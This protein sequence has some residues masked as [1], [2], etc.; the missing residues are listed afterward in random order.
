[1]IIEFL[2][3]SFP[4]S[5][6]VLRPQSATQLA[7]ARLA[8]DHCTSRLSGPLNLVCMR[9]MDEKSSLA[10]QILSVL[11][12]I[13]EMLE[14]A[15]PSGP[16]WFGE[17]FTLTDVAFAPF[18]TK[19]CVSSLSSFTTKAGDSG[20]SGRHCHSVG[21]D[22]AA[23]VEESSTG[24]S[25]CGVDDQV[26]RGRYRTHCDCLVVVVV[27]V[28]MMMMMMGGVVVVVVAADVLQMCEMVQ[29]G[30]IVWS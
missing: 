13:N 5:G 15:S 9:K 26:H 30:E 29:R 20:E 16:F 17:Q 11:Q 14:R 28:V 21:A 27:V 18:L 1:V 22:T 10:S 4:S 23:G 2:D 3:E 7:N 25:F 12:G 19:Y 6:S 8:A 24:A